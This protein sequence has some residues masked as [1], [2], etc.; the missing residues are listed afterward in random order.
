MTALI[1]KSLIQAKKHIREAAC[2]AKRSPDQIIL[3]AVSKR[4]PI[5]KLE[6]AIAAGQ[7]HF[8]ESQMQE[9]LPKIQAIHHPQINWHF[10]GAVQSNKTRG[11]AESFDWLHSLASIK[12]AERLSAQRPDRLPP[13]NVCIQINTDAEETKAGIDFSEVD[14]FVEAVQAL[15]GLRLRGLMCIP[16]RENN[17]E[18]FKKM[19]ACFLSLQQKRVEIDTLSMGMSDDFADA[20]ASGSTMVRLGSAIFG[21]R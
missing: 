10:I 11:I 15:P 6:A 14:D 20:I 9:A 17:R 8:G 3:L 13:L 16:A 12:H 1:E 18:A 19:Q 21:S 4:Q 2:L 5:S 7:T